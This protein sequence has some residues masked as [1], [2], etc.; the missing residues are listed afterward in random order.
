MDNI[1]PLYLI[2]HFLRFFMI[3]FVRNFQDYHLTTTM[4]EVTNWNFSLLYRN[5]MFNIKGA[6]WCENTIRLDS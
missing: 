1:S 2:G 3:Q 6:P 4:V 5:N